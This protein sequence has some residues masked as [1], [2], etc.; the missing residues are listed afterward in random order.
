MMTFGRTFNLAD[1]NGDNGFHIN[2]P[3][4]YRGN[5][6]GRAGD[7]NGD[8]ID[9]VIVG[10]ADAAPNGNNSSGASYIIFGIDTSST[11]PILVP[12]GGEVEQPRFDAT[13]N[14]SDLDGRN[15]FMFNHTG[16]WD[17][18]GGSV[19]TA[20]D[21]NG[22]GFDDLMVGAKY[23]YY[24]AEGSTPDNLLFG[25]TSGRAY[26]LFGHNQGFSASLDTS[27]LD[28][29][30]GFIIKGNGFFGLSLS[31]IGDVNGDGLD[32]IIIGA[33]SGSSV[34]F[35]DSQGFNANL[36]ISN[37]ENDNGFTISNGWSVDRAGDVNGD[38]IND[39]AVSSYNGYIIFGRQ[40]GFDTTPNVSTLDGSNGF[41]LTSSRAYITSGFDQELYFCFVNDAGDIN[42]DGSDDLI[43]TATFTFET[44]AGTG[45]DGFS[46]V[47]FGS[48]QGF[49]ATVDLANLDGSNGFLIDTNIEDSYVGFLG[50]GDPGKI[51]NGV[52]DINNDGFDDLAI[53]GD[54]GNSTYFIFGSDRGYPARLQP[55][56][57]DGTNGFKIRASVRAINAAGDINH[58]GYDDIILGGS[59]DAYVIFGQATATFGDDR[60]TGT[61]SNNEIRGLGG[62]DTIIGFAG[63][64]RL[65]GQSGNDTLFG[66]NGNDT[67]IGGSGNDTLSV[68][69]TRSGVNRLFGGSGDDI[70][71]GRSDLDRLVGQAGNDRLLGGGVL[72]GGTGQD[73]LFGKSGND[74]LFGGDG[75]DTLGGS[76]GRDRLY[77][78]N[79]NDIMYGGA[80]EDRLMGGAGNDRLMGITGN[81]STVTDSNDVLVGGSGH[82]VLI[83]GSGNDRLLGQAGNDRAFGDKGNDVLIGGL[84]RDRLAGQNGNDT[85]R[86]GADRDILLGGAGNDR[87]FGDM[88]NDVIITGA[89]RDNIVVRRGQ[90]RDFIRDFQNNF[91]TID[92]VGI[93]YHELTIQ[94]WQNNVLVKLGSTNLLVFENTNVNAIDRSDFV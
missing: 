8:G 13:V 51:A 83:A 81:D 31:D 48:R 57:L 86:G 94:Q 25:D 75:D 60:L 84:G 18:F 16:A 34:I 55:S 62:N 46:Y 28:G 35:G 38:G 40:D 33:S 56:D 19:S 65:L 36:D 89:G 20:G 39:I 80:G 88:G 32:D 54:R 42:G 12:R 74:T 29:D 67:L 76:L 21:I 58:D 43:I 47:L 87:I 27:S 68:S 17:L 50:L 77:G 44:R 15:G 79:G 7:I 61:N 91:D 41:K 73:E 53:L 72:V 63:D 52:G 37:L 64:D 78:Q 90:G 2:L 30:N 26:V 49:D 66:G 45:Y 92:L 6:V 70:L 82:D 22:D 14:V 11:D 93:G 10:A 9:D 71:R 23:A 85:L 4:S 24:Y 69:G 59:G 1:L 3:S 5:S